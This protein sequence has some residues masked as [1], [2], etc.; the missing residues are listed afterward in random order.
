MVNLLRRISAVFQRRLLGRKRVIA[1]ALVGILVALVAKGRVTPAPS[2]DQI[3]RIAEADI[4][5]SRLAD[6]EARLA[7]LRSLRVPTAEDWILQAQVSAAAGRDELALEAIDHVS[8]EHPLAAQLAYMA[9][10]IERHRG[11]LRFA[12]AAYRRA[13]QLDRRMVEAHKELVYLF[14]IQLRRREVDA[15]FR[16]LSRLTALSHHDLFTWCYTHFSSWAPDVTA[17]L[18]SFIKADPLDRH[19]RL[20]LA[21]L[22]LRTPGMEERVLRTLEPLPRSDVEATAL[23]IELELDHGRVEQAN[24]LLQSAPEHEQRLARLRGRMA[25]S[26]GEIT[27][28]I[29]NF[30]NALSEEPYERVALHDLG[31]ALLLAGDKQTAERYLGQATRLDSVYNLIS[32]VRRPD[33]ANVATDLTALADACAAAGLLS[34]ARGWYQLVIERNPLD[35]NAQRALWRLNNL[36]RDQPTELMPRR[37]NVSVVELYTDSKPRKGGY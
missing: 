37:D 6:A 1:L 19:S 28:A 10:R 27:K 20:A 13:I 5:A 11:R 4:Q 23:R 8:S 29:S 26:R 16:A 24:A 15:E 14:G 9:G 17:D 25:L 18:E 36:A 30:R 22:L 35:A 2:A 34:E 31:K 7:L 3:W 32:R 12:E 21:T 33:A